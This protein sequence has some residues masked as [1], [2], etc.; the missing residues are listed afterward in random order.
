MNPAEITP[1]LAG[2]MS[3]NDR[4]AL[5]VLTMD[6]CRVKHEAQTEK[7][8]QRLCEAWLTLHGFRRRSPEDIARPGPCA[9]WFIHLH[10]TRQNPILLDLLILFQSGK[11]IEIELKT[12]TGKPS[13]EQKAL[14]V[15]GGI[16]CRTLESFI[17]IIVDTDAGYG[18]VG[19]T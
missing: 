11:Y 15:R 16:L 14:L 9:G 7:E 12:S 8:L 4:K 19:V 3:A 6:E 2:M 1:K 18:R 17:K 5:G 10:E 13:E